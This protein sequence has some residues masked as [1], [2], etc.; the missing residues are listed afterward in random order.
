MTYDAMLYLVS[1]QVTIAML[2]ITI[3]IL[4]LDVAQERILGVSYKYIFFKSNMFG[5]FNITECIFSMLGLM[6]YSIIC[7]FILAGIDNYQSQRYS[8]F[9]LCLSMA[10]TM[11]LMFRMAWLGMIA[12][13]KKSRIYERIQK[14]LKKEYDSGK[15]KESEIFAPD[16]L[17]N[18]ILFSLDDNIPSSVLK[19][20]VLKRYNITKDMD[21]RLSDFKK[22]NNK[23]RAFNEYLGAESEILLFILNME[24]KNFSGLSCEE[25]NKRIEQFKKM[26]MRIYYYI[27]CAVCADTRD[28]E[29]VM[30]KIKEY[31]SFNP[32]P[33]RRLFLRGSD[34]GM[35]GECS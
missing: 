26:E 35:K 25:Q 30:R 1:I 13:Y 7:T 23:N 16:T 34:R 22:I 6:A 17:R 32:L 11:A 15:Q 3:M 21:L 24:R 9:G 10:G 12:K 18:K 8:R 31:E 14:K 29:K 27:Q 19:K 33:S 5:K 28:Y 2:A 20:K 4:F